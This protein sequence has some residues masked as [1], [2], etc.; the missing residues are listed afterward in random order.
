LIRQLCVFLA[1]L[2]LLARP[3]LGDDGLL[4]EGR[5]LYLE[6]QRADGSPLEGWR[7]GGE[8]LRG[9]DM[10]CVQ[11]H[12]RSGMGTVEGVV[13]VPPVAGEALFRP[14]QPASGHVPRRADGMT[15]Q[16]HAFRTRPAYDEASLGRALR[17]G[18]GAGEVPFEPLMPR[19]ILGN[20]EIAALAAWMR[21]LGSTPA[22]GVDD[23]ASGGMLHLATVIAP[24]ADPRQR[25][26]MRAVLQRCVA[27][28]SVAAGQWSPALAAR[29]MAVVGPAGRLAGP[30]GRAHAQSAGLCPARRCRPRMAAGA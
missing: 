13:I 28:R 5:R 3:V 6:G 21:S 26:A 29:R 16:D 18:I 30:V 1:L 25:D 12:R 9:R 20:R 17:D 11:C 10:A 4:A 24:D 14:G 19:Y 7:P 15:L 8:R 22:P 2:V 27:Q 23:A